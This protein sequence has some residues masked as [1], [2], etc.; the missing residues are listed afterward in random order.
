MNSIRKYLEI[1]ELEEV[2][3]LETLNH[4]FN[5]LLKVYHPDRNRDRPVWAHARTLDLLEASRELREYIRVRTRM[6]AG[7]LSGRESKPDNFRVHSY[8]TSREANF[9][10]M[11][12]A[13][14]F[15]TEVQIQLIDRKDT[16]YAIPVDS[17][18]RIV[19]SRFL[20]EHQSSEKICKYE[21]TIYRIMIPDDSALYEKKVEFI[22]LCKLG[23]ENIALCFPEEIEFGEI[24]SINSRQ[25]V[26][27]ANSENLFNH[28]IYIDGKAYRFPG[29]D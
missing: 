1:L 6:P 13:G 14:A 20:S 9:S 10:S 7:N 24:Q 12:G 19:S 27:L 23:G 8:K 25:I 26:K 16:G 2:P 29:Y 28:L 22:V 18:V 11:R 4:R 21:G 15:Y 5:R 17:V 3:D